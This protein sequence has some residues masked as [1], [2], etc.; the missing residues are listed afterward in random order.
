MHRNSPTGMKIDSFWLYHSP[1]PEIPII[2]TPCEP[3]ILRIITKSTV[4]GIGKKVPYNLSILLILISRYYFHLEDCILTCLW[5]QTSP[6]R[7]R[8]FVLYNLS[9]INIQT[10]A[11]HFHLE[12]CILTHT[13][14]WFYSFSGIQQTSV[15]NGAHLTLERL[16]HIQVLIVETPNWF[17]K[18]GAP[19]CT[20]TYLR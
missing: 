14:P 4:R 12:Q 16:L 13:I 15:C 9:I 17:W 20:G 7:S 18:F 3:F 5:L 2:H 10:L 8:Q 1:P 6:T 19:R 11:Y